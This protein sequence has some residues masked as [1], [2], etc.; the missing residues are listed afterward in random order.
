MKHI[1][2]KIGGMSCSACSNSLEKFLNKQDGIIEAK[3]NLV[4]ACASIDYD[5][6]INLQTINNYI[7]QS[8]FTAEGLFKIE[9]D[10]T[11]YQ[12]KLVFLI[13]YSV[14]TLLVLYLAMSKMLNLP[15]FNILNIDQNPKIH[16]LTLFV[17]SLPY[18][19]YG[20]KIFKNGIKNIIYLSPNMETLVTIGFFS[21][22][23]YSTINMIL[24]LSDSTK[25]LPLYFDCCTV[26]ILFVNL[27]RLIDLKAKDK[28]KSAIKDLVQITPSKAFLKKGNETIETTIDEINVDD[29]LI[30][31]AGDKVAVDGI[32]LTGEC[33]IDESFLT[34]ESK[35][36]KKTI[37]SSVI[38][39]SILHNGYIEYSAKKIGKASTIS[40]IVRLVV[41]ATNSKAKISKIADKISS[42]FVP[43]IMIIAFITFIIYLLI[44]KSFSTAITTFV[45]VLVVACPCALG[46]A[47]PL[48]MVISTGELAKRGILIKQNNILENAH[49]INTVVFDKTG[50]LTYGM[51]KIAEII[52]YYEGFIEYAVSLESK[53]NHPISNAF[54]DF[55]KENKIESKDVT[56]VEIIN[57]IGIKGTIDNKLVYL[58]NNKLFNI[59]NIENNYK[60]DEDYL[61]NKGHSIV[62]VIIDNKVFGIIGISD[63]IRN[64]AKDIVKTLKHKNINVIMLT[65]DNKETASIIGRELGINNIISE[66]MP[67]DKVK[68]IENLI[69][70]N[71]EVMMIGD[72]VND[73]PALTLSKIG[74]SINSGSDI[75]MNS[76]DVILMNNDLNQ[77]LDLIYI[78]KKTIINIKENL[79]WAFFYNLLMIPLAIGCFSPLGISLNPMFAA[80][81]M[82]LSSLT[83]TLNALRLLKIK[84][85]GEQHDI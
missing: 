54:K 59:L 40:E 78:S 8:G 49:K 77:I 43:S 21:S 14:L 29:I 48:A 80:I 85:K 17:L 68:I 71:K 1:T 61:K 41:D 45:S 64:E 24:I 28:T 23:I 60:K 22:F 55:Q 30:C 47:T 44:G 9:N 37:N 74:I 73:A 33:Y 83:V 50:T 84:I 53:S 18:L 46:L 62:F 57:G 6:S 10:H 32:I 67:Q 11:E 52:T 26:L 7:K 75:A 12:R 25:V 70:D 4:L 3:V 42:Y 19:I 20:F 35:P 38:A 13:T 81:G 79:F 5:E 16:A 65:G 56:N 15:I 2:L 69:K 27:G 36:V 63:I 76:A 39:G 51:Q 82:T 58:G 34:G 31:K 66:V 72:G